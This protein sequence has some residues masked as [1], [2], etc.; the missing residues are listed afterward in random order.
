MFNIGGQANEWNFFKN[1][2][3]TTNTPVGT[4]ID[5][6]W[7]QILYKTKFSLF[8]D[9]IFET[10]LSDMARYDQEGN[11]EKNIVFPWRLDI[12]PNP[13]I[14]AMFSSEQPDDPLDYL[15]Q[16]SSVPA[17]MV[18]WEVYGWDK[19]KQLGGKQHHI[20]SLKL[21]GKMTTSRWGDENLFMR[22]QRIEYDHELRPEWA[23]YYATYSD[24][25]H[26]PYERTLKNIGLY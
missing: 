19:P 8:T 22:H 21:Q 20:G 4:Y 17:D 5:D 26:C 3:M 25:G 18:L 13:E 2:F 16:L 12:K 15:K 23:P 1:D 14:T 7:D 24:R 10:G 6:K 11:E 9:Y